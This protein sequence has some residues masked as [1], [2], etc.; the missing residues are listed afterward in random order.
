MWE[1]SSSQEG[2]REALWASNG[3]ARDIH[4]SRI[5]GV[6][7][8]EPVVEEVSVFDGR[9]ISVRHVSSGSISGTAVDAGEDI[10]NLS[11][12]HSKS[13]INNIISRSS[14]VGESSKIS[15]NDAQRILFS[16]GGDGCGGVESNQI[17]ERSSL[18]VLE[19][20][21]AG[22]TLEEDVNQ[23]LSGEIVR[24]EARK[25]G[26]EN[27]VDRCKEERVKNHGKSGVENIVVESLSE[28]RVESIPSILGD[29]SSEELVDQRICHSGLLGMMIGTE[30]SIVDGFSS[31]PDTND[32][33]SG[34]N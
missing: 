14:S 2:R 5:W 16:V 7:I 9:S 21:K 13:N 27:S 31:G 6:K 28:G 18:V 23:I 29:E 1:G 24:L 3:R 25:I 22:N 11:H 15:I 17:L 26:F 19:G 30:S 32:I 20:I 8:R 33:V 10:T 4:R 12:E 34:S